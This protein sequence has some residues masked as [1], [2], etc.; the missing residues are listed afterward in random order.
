M[1]EGIDTADIEQE[2]FP[3]TDVSS[4]EL[5]VV[6]AEQKQEASDAVDAVNWS[7]LDSER[8]LTDEKVESLRQ[9]GNALTALSRTLSRRVPEEQYV[10]GEECREMSG[11][12]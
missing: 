2:S 4:D 1:I 5:A 12:R 10:E 9:V 11:D 6:L 8:P 7:L 3:L